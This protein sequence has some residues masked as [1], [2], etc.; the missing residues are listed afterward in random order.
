MGVGAALGFFSTFL[1]LVFLV[2]AIERIGAVT[3]SM[4]SVIGPVVA[5]VIGWLFFGET[6]AW[7]QVAGAALLIGSVCLLLFGRARS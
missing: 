4:F 2:A 3:T 6:L 1:P 7:P 5:V